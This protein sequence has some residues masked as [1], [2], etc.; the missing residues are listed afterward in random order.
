MAC[1]SS[2]NCGTPPCRLLFMANEHTQLMEVTWKTLLCSWSFALS[3]SVTIL[4]AVSTGTNRRHY[5]QRNPTLLHQTPH[6]Y[7][8][9]VQL[10]RRL[11]W[12]CSG[13]HGL[14]LVCQTALG[15]AEQTQFK[16]KT[17]ICDVCFKLFPVTRSA[18]SEPQASSLMYQWLI[19]HSPPLKVV[20]SRLNSASVRILI[21][22]VKIKVISMGVNCN[23]ELKSIKPVKLHADRCDNCEMEGRNKE[24]TKK[25]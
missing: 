24:K 15:T 22:D 19:L 8:E 16:N 10:C 5:F 21:Q 9:V 12:C 23:S 20:V 1:F 6:G 3:T 25:K 7:E 11:C 17:E 4:F 2:G 14:A 18:W 13:R